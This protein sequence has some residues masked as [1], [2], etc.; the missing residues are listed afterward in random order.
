[1]TWR[2]KLMNFIPTLFLGL[3][4]Y[5]FVYFVISTSLI[6][7]VAFL[8]CIYFVPVCAFRIHN[9]L[10]PLVYGFSNLSEKKYSSWWGGHQIQGIYAT[11]PVFERV[12]RII[13]GFY[14]GWLRLWGSTVGKNVYWTPMIEIHDR[15]SVHIGDDVIF[16][17]KV[18]CYCHI[19]KPRHDGLR[20]YL[21][22]IVIGSRTFVGAG[23][24]IGPGVQI[25]E[26]TF[27]PLLTDLA[28]NQQHGES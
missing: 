15:G 1:M 21:Q 27:V 7:L 19:I 11:F 5:S 12:L 23:A 13:P 16:G 22:P 25:D 17:H 3:I 26:D 10:S 6:A 14:S 18:E 4:F 9:F 2:S 20:L 24:R 28:I 8:I